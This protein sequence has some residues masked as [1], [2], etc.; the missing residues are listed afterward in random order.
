MLALVQA[1]GLP[2][3]SQEPELLP[4]GGVCVCGNACF[5]SDVNEENAQSAAAGD[6]AAAC[7][8]CKPGLEGGYAGS[9]AWAGAWGAAPP[10]GWW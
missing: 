10:L 8:V 2:A 3:G 1:K 7:A 4:G 9:G 6:P 5:R